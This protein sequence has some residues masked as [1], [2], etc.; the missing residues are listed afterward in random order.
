MSRILAPQLALQII[1][2][3]RAQQLP[4]DTPLRTQALADQFKVSRAPVIAALKLLAG[5][6]VLYAERNRGY[7]LA[8]DAAQI[9]SPPSSDESIED[10]LYYRLAED[11]LTVQVPER[12]SENELMRR[13]EVPRSL[14]RNVLQ[15]AADDLWL[16]RLPGHGWRFLPMLTSQQSY[17]E[18]YRFRVAL[19]PQALLEP[20]FRVDLAALKIL[21]SQQQ[22]LLA[23]DI[24]HLS[25]S[26][27]FE[28]NSEFH[29]VLVGFSGNPFFVDAVKKV[30][31]VRRLLD[32]RSTLD[33]TRLPRQC[34]EHLQI[35]DLLERGEILQAAEVLRQHLQGAL[36]SKRGLVTSLR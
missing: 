18:G 2:H 19:E 26:N 32:Y 14:L 6:G 3:V 31:R 22:A 8:R 24:A 1:E 15:R 13:Y 35:L 4:A 20:G 10:D 23:G 34:E 12:C 29:E 9:A 33:R 30:N 36:A 21:R 27:L 11:F 5:Q 28:L 25:R 17:E 7:F 16:E